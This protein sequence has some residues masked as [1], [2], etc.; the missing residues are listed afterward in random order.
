MLGLLQFP[1]P[2]FQSSFWA[3]AILGKT[4]TP[5]AIRR[6]ALIEADSFGREDGIVVMAADSSG[7]ITE[8]SLATLLAL[9]LQAT[10]IG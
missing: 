9:Y 3:A 10:F 6:R 2:P 1:F 8:V 5:N 7:P 4:A